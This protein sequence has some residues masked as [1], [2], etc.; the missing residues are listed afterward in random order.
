MEKALLTTKEVAKI[1]RRSVVT[2]GRWVSSGRLTA[3][4]QGG[5]RKGPYVFR[6]E[7]LDAFNESAATGPLSGKKVAV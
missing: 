2:I 5:N 6:Q 1:Y 3:I 7:D 4:N